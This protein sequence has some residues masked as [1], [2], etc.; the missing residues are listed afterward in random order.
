MLS[1]LMASFWDTF[2]GPRASTRKVGT[3]VWLCCHGYPLLFVAA[4]FELYEESDV[5]AAVQHAV[6]VC[7]CVCVE[8]GGVYGHVPLEQDCEASLSHCLLSVDTILSR[9]ALPPPLPSFSHVTVT[10]SIGGVPCI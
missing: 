3:W 7:V 8:G 6:S 10:N 4:S 2:R 1:Q 5:W 9:L